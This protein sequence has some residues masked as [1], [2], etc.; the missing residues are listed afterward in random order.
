MKRALLALPLFLAAAFA[1]ADEG[2][3]KI[4]PV[5]ELRQ[6]PAEMYACYDFETAKKILKLDIDLQLTL[7]KCTVCEQDRTDLRVAVD[8]LKLATA[9]DKKIIDNLTVRLTEKQATLEKTTLE[10]KKAEEH[11]VWRYLPWIIAGATILAAGSFVAGWYL[12]TH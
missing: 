12:S 5:W 7:E 4:F 8:K 2:K 3:M 1:A 9:E 10:L 6:C 11:T